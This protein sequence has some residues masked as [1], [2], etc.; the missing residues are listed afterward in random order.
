MQSSD[1]QTDPDGPRSQAPSATEQPTPTAPGEEERDTADDQS[2]LSRDEIFGLLSNPRR[3]AAI[4]YLVD[5]DEDTVQL[6]DLAEQ[7]A[8]WEN[9]VD[10]KEVTYKQRKRVYTS[11]YQSHLSKMDDAGVVEFDKHRGTVGRRERARGLHDYLDAT[12]GDAGWSHVSLAAA[13]FCLAVV[14]LAWL[15][16]APGAADGAPVIGTVVAIV[17][18]AVSAAQVVD[19]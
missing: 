10:P 9:D 13:L 14:G 1:L 3:R 12:D 8:A 7:L 5:E 2:G 4:R 16:V 6:R 11:L 19:R 17:F 18:L 15:G